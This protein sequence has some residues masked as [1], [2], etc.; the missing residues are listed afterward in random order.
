MFNLSAFI[1]G[2]TARSLP[3]S[4]WC[5]RWLGMTVVVPV[6]AL[7]FFT[8]GCASIPF[9]NPLDLD[10]SSRQDASPQAT[11]VSAQAQIP[12]APAPEPPRASPPVL[13]SEPQPQAPAAAAVESQP[14]AEPSAPAPAAVPQD[15]PVAPLDLTPDAILAAT[16]QVLVDIYER[17]RPSVVQIRA[18]RRLDLQ[19][20]PSGRA[21]LPFDTRRSA[22]SGFV[23]DTEGHIVTNH[24][25]V[26]GADIVL[27]TFSDGMELEATVMGTDPD[28]DLAVLRVDA[29]EEG[30]ELTP[31]T[32]GDSSAVKV[33]H[34]SSAIGNPF[35]QEFTITSGIVSAVGR[36]IRSGNSPF[37]IPRVIQT[38]A[39]MNPGNSGGPLL[40]RRGRV[41]GVN[42]QIASNTGA[43]AGIGFAVP[44]NTAKRVIP[45]LIET[46]KYEYAWLGISGASLTA[47]YA[48]LN[49][50]PRDTRG[51]LVIEVAADSPASSAGL[52][53]SDQVA[54]R[55]GVEVPVGGDVIIAVDGTGIADMDELIAFLIEETRP[56]DTVRIDVIRQ[57]GESATL[58]ATLASRPSF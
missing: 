46:G 26:E 57:G 44:I 50:L 28:S 32:L 36:T 58:E 1:P 2:A 16:E 20:G 21:P 23:W 40:D 42:T 22:G 43:S 48:E 39:P 18:I 31:V 56:G 6:F 37:S 7:L 52:K 49:G 34:L 19:R 27:V 45:E 51:A 8:A 30:Y 53:G 4:L 33:G 17:V 24:H 9:G 41:I 11:E 5:S 38:D 54:T 55:Q 13:Q 3:R 15:L 14:P 12:A 35:G 29:G 47:E 25:V 10:P